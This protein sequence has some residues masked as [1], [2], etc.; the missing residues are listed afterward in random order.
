MTVP[1]MTTRWQ[2]KKSWNDVKSAQANKE[3]KAGPFSLGVTLTVPQESLGAKLSN[4]MCPEWRPGVGV[5]VSREGGKELHE[6]FQKNSR[7]RWSN[8]RSV[9]EHEVLEINPELTE[10]ANS[11][12]ELIAACSHLGWFWAPSPPPQGTFGCYYNGGGA[13]GI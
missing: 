13:P 4:S 7:P 11:P 5:G 2:G 8:C 10:C 9:E 12:K 3:L 1:Q 6:K